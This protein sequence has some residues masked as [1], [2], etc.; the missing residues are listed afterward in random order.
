MQVGPLAA[1]T[2]SCHCTLAIVDGSTAVRGD[3]PDWFGPLKGTFTVL[4]LA[5]VIPVTGV[6]GE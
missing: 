1:G 3:P 5:L 4:A 2:V 6:C